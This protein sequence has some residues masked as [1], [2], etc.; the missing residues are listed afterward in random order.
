MHDLAN[1]AAPPLP[2]Q[3]VVETFPAIPGYRLLRRLG[4]GGMATVYLAT[5]ESLDRPVGI[6]VMD[7]DALQD[8]TSR[9]R[10]E[11]EARTIANLTHPGIVGI[12]EVGRTVDGLMYYIMPYLAKGDLSRIDIRDDEARIKD[13]L[14]TLLSALDYAHERG[15]VH[16]DVKQEN[17]LFDANDRPLLADFGIS[18]S[19]NDT[20]RVT[21]EGRSVGSSA[22]MSPEQA[23]GE[24]VDGR[25]DLYSVGVM[26]YSLLTGQ[27]PFHAPDALALA[28]MHAQDAVPR[29]PPAKRQWQGFIDR[30][31][32]KSPA[33]RFENAKQMLQAL[34][35]IRTRPEDVSSRV[36]RAIGVPE[37][38]GWKRFRMLALASVLV[39]LSGVYAANAWIAARSL[40]PP[41]HPAKP[42]P[43]VTQVPSST[44][45]ASPDASSAASSADQPDNATKQHPVAHRKPARK[46]NFFSRMLHRL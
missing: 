18:L 24:D 12:H 22:Y 36:L 46:R 35:A 39:V 9:Q 17:V 20:S 4:K 26:T 19:R 5:Q 42:A 28:L 38:S 7:R 31:M 44:P 29:L 37:G 16:R 40:P 25:T 13:V 21:M 27:L 3:D 34:E 14:R 32:A 45:A 30:A 11:N 43:G 15:T 6:K 41:T 2:D 8:E 33:Q 23:R 10:F 1:P